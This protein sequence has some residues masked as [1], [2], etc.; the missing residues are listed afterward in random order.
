MNLR[1]AQDRATKVVQNLR[2]LPGVLSPLNRSA[3]WSE[4]EPDNYESYHHFA[5]A[6][7][8]ALLP[9]YA[10]FRQVPHL[11]YEVPEQMVQIDDNQAWYFLNGIC[12]S[13]GALRVNGRALAT[14][15][16]RRI[17]LM[18]NPSDGVVLDLAECALG[19]KMQFISTLESSVAG[20]LE[21]ALETRDKVVLIVHSQGGIISSN[22]LYLLRERLGAGRKALLGKLELYSFASAATE[23]EMPEIHAEHFFHTEDYVARIGVAGYPER[24]SGRL[25]PAPG[26]GHLLNAH[27]LVSFVNG[28]FEPDDGPPS[29]LWR[30]LR[31]RKVTPL[32]EGVS[33]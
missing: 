11:P 5:Y 30:Y 15:F 14:L 26:S 23:L 16:N 9:I 19:R 21:Q 32:E 18:H 20:I 10:P 7:Y 28:D 27:Y 31:Q 33:A 25:F 12:T 1:D 13:R 29:Q 17:Y 2:Y 24:F 6:A 4:F 8:S 22:A 3:P